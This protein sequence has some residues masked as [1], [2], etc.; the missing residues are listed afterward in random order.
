MQRAPSNRPTMAPDLPDVTIQCRR[1]IRRRRRYATARDDL[2][3]LGTWL[4]PMPRRRRPTV[5]DARRDG[6]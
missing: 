6:A 1:N 2:T 4:A 5:V 3:V